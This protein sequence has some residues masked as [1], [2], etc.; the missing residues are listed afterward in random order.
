LA[1]MYFDGGSDEDIRKVLGQTFVSDPSVG[2][3]AQLGIR[4]Y[5]RG[6]QL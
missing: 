2:R 3:D 1:V 6:R 4:G 5:P